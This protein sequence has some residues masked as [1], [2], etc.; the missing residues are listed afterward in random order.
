MYNDWRHVFFVYPPLIVIAAIAWDTLLRLHLSQFVNR[1]C[2]GLLLVILGQPLLWSVRNHPYESVYF[3]PIVGGVDGAFGYYEMDYWGNSLRR[4][5]EWLAQ[6]EHLKQAHVIVGSIGA[7][8]TAAVFY[9]LRKYNPDRYLP[10]RR[11]NPKRWD[12]ALLVSREQSQQDLLTGWPPQN[13]IYRT[14]VDHTV[15]A[16]VVENP[17]HE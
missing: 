11:S 16:V 7:S 10:V 13:T 3:N 15:L 1:C 5:A 9:Y 14:M 4:T 8:E 12:Y 6:N 17:Q 2:W